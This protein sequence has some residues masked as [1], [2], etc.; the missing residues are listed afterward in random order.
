MKNKLTYFVVCFLFLVGSTILEGTENDLIHEFT[1]LQISQISKALSHDLFEVLG[2]EVGIKQMPKEITLSLPLF[3]DPEKEITEERK[4]V[5]LSLRMDEVD[6]SEYLDK[7]ENPE[8]VTLQM[9]GDDFDDEGDDI[10]DEDEP[11]YHRAPQAILDQETRD[12][13]KN[14]LILVSIVITPKIREGHELFIVTFVDGWVFQISA[15][16]ASGCDFIGGGIIHL[17]H[18]G[19]AKFQRKMQRASKEILEILKQGLEGND[20]ITVFEGK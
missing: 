1:E 13:L 12:L 20:K 9:D 6:F 2:G 10:T 18:S 11:E 17:K 14:E 16:D 15:F 3:N 8:I 5:I 19:I 7:Y 4:K